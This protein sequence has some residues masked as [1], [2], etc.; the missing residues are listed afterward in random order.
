M[1]REAKL[2]P[3]S[4]ALLSGKKLA[5][6]NSNKLTLGMRR[7]I[8]SES[9][10]QGK[11]IACFP[12]RGDSWFSCAKVHHAPSLALHWLIPMHVSAAAG[13]S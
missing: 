9:A 6:C 2:V 11:R 8:P 12:P 3:G 4:V 7:A 13:D 5:S 10:K 1:A